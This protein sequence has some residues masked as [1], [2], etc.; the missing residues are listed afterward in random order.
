ML[1]N[2]GSSGN[3][4]LYDPAPTDDTI[5]Q[6][7]KLNAV[8]ATTVDRWHV[9]FAAKSFQEGDTITDG[10]VGGDESLNITAPDSD[11]F[12]FIATPISASYMAKRRSP[13]TTAAPT[14]TFDS[15]NEPTTVL[16]QSTYPM[17][18]PGCKTDVLNGTIPKGVIID[19]GAISS[20]EVLYTIRSVLCTDV[21]E[22]PPGIPAAAA[23][24]QQSDGAVAC[25]IS[26]AISDAIEAWGY[27][28]TLPDGVEAQECWDST[29]YIIDRCI[30]N[31][32]KTTGWW[33][34]DHVYQFYQLGFR[35]LNYKE[36]YHYEADDNLTSVLT[37]VATVPSFSTN[38][39]AANTTTAG[40]VTVSTLPTAAATTTAASGEVSTAAVSGSASATASS[41]DAALPTPLRQLL[42]GL[43]PLAM[44]L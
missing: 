28:G 30:V 24:T 16:T 18:S 12:M 15:R 19:N 8:T 10:D 29:A 7:V 1:V 42:M 39:F 9:E 2:Y 26:V 32:N 34:G 33:N 40:G 35:P 22:I 6:S 27:R 31:A 25:E 4:D 41:G 37:T 23:T 3:N 14:K 17:Q 13:Q 20:T 44:W 21:C 36:T 38:L 5:T 11:A 43:V